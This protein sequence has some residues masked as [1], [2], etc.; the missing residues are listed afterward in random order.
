MRIRQTAGTSWRDPRQPGVRHWRSTSVSAG[1]DEWVLGWIAWHLVIWPFFLLPLWLSA[2]C[3]IV[4]ASGLSVVAEW[5]I[6]P[7][8]RYRMESGRWG[9]FWYLRAGDV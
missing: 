2:E 5:A 1:L 6:N 4:L 9:P 7:A 3:C 8:S